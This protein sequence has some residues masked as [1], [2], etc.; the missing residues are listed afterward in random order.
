MAQLKICA[1]AMEACERHE[2]IADI[3]DILIPIYRKRRRYVSAPSSNR[4]VS[5][6]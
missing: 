6:R 3:Y 2:L 5:R 4:A 1:D